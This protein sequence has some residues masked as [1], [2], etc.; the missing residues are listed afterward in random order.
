MTAD[1]I[2]EV[3]DVVISMAHEL[4][5]NDVEQTLLDMARTTLDAYED[6]T[7]K[8]LDTSLIEDEDLI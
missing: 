6:H 5:G 7:G 1:L 2:L 3:L 8:V 4:D